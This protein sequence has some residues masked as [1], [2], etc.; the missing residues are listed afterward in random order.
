[1]FLFQNEKK[2]SQLKNT[3]NFWA[4]FNC[5][6]VIF[7]KEEF[8]GV[9]APLPLGIHRSSDACIPVWAPKLCAQT[10]KELI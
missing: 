6:D 10:K 1:M 5:F 9:K 7:R 4:N 3:S 2:W 8:S